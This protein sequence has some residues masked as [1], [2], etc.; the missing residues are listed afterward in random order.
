M[1]VRIAY[2][3][4]ILAIVLCMHALYGEKIK[5]TK[6]HVSTAIF[7]AVDV[8]CLSIIYQFG[9]PQFFTF[10]L[11]AF[12]VVYCGMRFGFHWKKICVNVILCIV[13][14]TVIQVALVTILQ[15]LFPN[16]FGD[17]V[18]V[19][20]INLG[21]F[22]VTIP[23][24]LCK[25]NKLSELLQ[26]KEV[27]ITLSVVVVAIA[28]CACIV[29]YKER[30][31]FPWEV[32]VLLIILVVMI[33]VLAANFSRIRIKAKTDEAELN[34]FRMYEES[35]QN[36]IT[37]IRLRQH[38]FDNQI[39]AVYSQQYVYK[40]YDSLVNAQKAYCQ[41][42]KNSNKYNKL[43]SSGN[44]VLIGFLYGKFLELDEKQID[45]TY[46]VAIGKAESLVPIYVM[47]ELLGNLLNNAA[48]ALLETEQKRLDF[49]LIEN[50]ESI[51]IQVKN[52]A[53]EYDF[54]TLHS[55]FKKG[56]SSK[57]EGR[58]LGLY[59]VK[60]RCDE[61]QIQLSVEN[62]SCEYG[63]MISFGLIIPKK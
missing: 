53:P 19:L 27:L 42:L 52:T 20:L 17:E 33:F 18:E 12:L 38:E 31:Y 29:M 9:L 47:V 56:N 51:V 41:D 46:K 37:N 55:F 35:F 63:N 28:T 60:C 45:L 8:I 10:I 21:V 16:G 44:P 13:V 62:E 50:D 23:L 48:D 54:D 40:D 30:V 61:Y 49:C 4:E 36:L 3:F 22:I 32:F 39:N 7:V 26:K 34:M 6:F 2:V 25:L 15:F 24:Q 14:L 58:G 59:H 11:Y 1:I 43:L 57:G 5:L